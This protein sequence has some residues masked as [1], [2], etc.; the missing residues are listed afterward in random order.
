MYGNFPYCIDKSGVRIFA[1]CYCY[2][3]V[4]NLG[5]GSSGK[6]SYSSCEI[7]KI[8][9]LAFV[10]LFINLQFSFIFDPVKYMRVCQEEEGRPKE[11]PYEVSWDR[12]LPIFN[13]VTSFSKPTGTF[14]ES[15]HENICLFIWFF[16]TASNNYNNI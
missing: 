5:N 15:L 11:W 2:I 6:A 12:E 3:L 14:I 7:H 13:L 8:F 4:P 9:I 1:L 16:L 10:E